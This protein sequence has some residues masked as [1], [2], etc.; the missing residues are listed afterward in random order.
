MSKK[1]KEI[2]KPNKELNEEEF[3]QDFW[4]KN[5]LPKQ[6]E[7][8]PYDK[9][10]H[11]EQKII[12]K[13]RKGK[14]LKKHELDIIKQTTSKYQ[15][16]LKKYDA[17]EITEAYEEFN[18]IIQTE[19][20]LLDL[21]DAQNKPQKLRMKCRFNINGKLKYKI[22][23]FTVHP[24]DDS[25]AVEITQTHIDIFQNLNPK[26]NNILLKHQKGETLT[27]AEKEVIE[28]INKKVMGEQLEE[29]MEAVNRLLA[30]Q[31]TPPS[32][33]TLEERMKFWE[34][35]HFNDKMSLFLRVQD[36]L[37]LTEA[38]DNE[39]FLDE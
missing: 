15:V 13:I 5:E 10:T 21:V 26:E 27:Q 34:K 9:L 23:E 31:V 6:V 28:H 29:R 33:G 35:F 22:I 8:L 36:L 39:L 16:A 20:E 3:I 32:N 2:I 19:Q 14:K 25:R 37:G 1:N 18:D 17:E 12:N 11:K 7:T 4:V 38:R 30:S 24:L